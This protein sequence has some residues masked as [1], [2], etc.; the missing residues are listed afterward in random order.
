MYYSIVLL[1]FIFEL[2]LLLR[3]QIVDFKEIFTAE[4]LQKN[5][6]D[7]AMSVCLSAYLYVRE[8]VSQF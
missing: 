3:I 7:L 5:K 2:E 8:K 1:K 4:C 6:M